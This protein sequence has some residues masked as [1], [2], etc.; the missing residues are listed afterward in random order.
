MMAQ[1]IAWF[2]WG[3]GIG[4]LAGISVILTILVLLTP[5][6]AGYI[7][8]GFERLQVTLL[9]KV[10]RNFAYFFVNYATF[11]GT[12]I[13]E[14]SHAVFAAITGAKVTEICMFESSNGRLGHIR[15]HNRG[16]FFMHA[17]QDTLTAVAPTVVGFSLGYFLLQ[18]IFGGH[19][20]L[21][22]NIGLWYLVI[23]LVDHSTMSDAD[24]KNY[25]HGSWLFAILFFV[26][27][28]VLGLL[29]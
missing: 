20:S 13:H 2:G 6:I 21:L 22:A 14:M 18:Y 8:Y 23:S 12:F 26:L 1:V 3:N 29:A 9:G 7:L 5:V 11:P 19:H 24:M 15:Y 25:F 27:F 10:N 16:P 17:V 28:L 4:A